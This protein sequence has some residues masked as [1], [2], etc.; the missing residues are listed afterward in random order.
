MEDGTLDLNTGKFRADPLD[1]DRRDIAIWL[2]K[3]LVGVIALSFLALIWALACGAGTTKE[4][5]EHIVGLLNIVF[6][7][8]VTL[9]GAATGYYFGA[10]TLN[11]ARQSL[12]AAPP[13]PPSPA[14][15]PAPPAAPPAPP[16]PAA[17][18]AAPLAP[19]PPA[20]P[21]PP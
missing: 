11:A 17:P 18:P 6:G 3:I 9:V 8:V 5:F 1:S 13:A 21:P 10:Q 12:G 2:L 15:P 7:P 20:D 16:P 14:A 19:P 4:N